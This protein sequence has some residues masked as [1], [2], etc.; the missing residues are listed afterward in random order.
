MRGGEEERGAERGRRVCGAGGEEIQEMRVRR[1]ELG[2]VRRV[3]AVKNRVLRMTVSNKLRD[4]EG[5][6]YTV[7]ACLCVFRM[8]DS[9]SR[10]TMEDR[11]KQNREEQS[12]A[13][14]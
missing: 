10:I 7:Y 12:T 3:G 4:K 9:R 13:V 1:G 8:Y 14:S 2:G 11:T 5:V 6:H